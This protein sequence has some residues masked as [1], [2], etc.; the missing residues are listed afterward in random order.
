MSLDPANELTMT[1]VFDAPREAVWRACREVEAL[2]AWWGM[3]EGAS[4]PHCTIDF[5]EGGSLHF[6]TTRGGRPVMW[7]KCVYLSIVEP[8]TLIMEQHRS[9]E[10]GRVQDSDEWP[11]SRISLQLEELGGKTRM[12]VTHAGMASGRATV[13][14]YRQGWTETLDRLAR[15]LAEG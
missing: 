14:D 2:K 5:R 1:R 10:A 8:Q 6:G 11:A 4:M 12:T 15:R 3:P 7:F 9:D 13:A